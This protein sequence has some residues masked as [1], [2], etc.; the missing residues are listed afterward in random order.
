LK[1]LSS[2]ARYMMADS[3]RRLL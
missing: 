3:T 1:E 2:A